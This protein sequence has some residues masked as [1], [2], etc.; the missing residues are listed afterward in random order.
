MALDEKEKK[1]SLLL[2]DLSSLEDYIHDLFNFSPLPICFVSP[3]G[4]IL[5]VNPAF[6]KISNFELNEIISGPIEKLFPKEE[7]E[8]LTQET[9]TKGIVEGKEMIFLPKEKGKMVVQVFTR[10]RKDEKGM[11][12]GYFLGIFDLTNI[13]K[14][15]TEIKETQRALLNMLEDTEEARRRSEEERSK[16]LTII[17]NFADGLL[18]FDAENR[19]SLINPEAEKFFNI[20]G[21]EIINRSI[22]EL[23]TVPSFGPLV[24]LVGKEIKRVFRKEFK[25]KEDLVLEI[26][27]IPIIREGEIIGT[28]IILH[29]ITREKMIER[30]KTEFV[31]ISAHQLRTPLSAIKWTLRMLLDGDLGEIT[32]EQRE[33]IEKTYSSNER[34]IK[35]INDLLN[36]TRIEEGRYLHKP[37]LTDIE[38]MIDTLINSFGEL[39]AR[40]KIKIEFKKPKKKTPMIEVDA[41]KIK[42]AINNLIDNAIRYNQPG[43]KVTVTLT[44]DRNK[45]KISVSDKGI[46][47]AKDQQKRVFTKFF[48]SVNAMRIE[49]EGTG[50]GLFIAKNIIEAHG[51]K[52]WFESAEGKGTTFYL[53]LP[54]KAPELGKFLSASQTMME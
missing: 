1:I 22:S 33:L 2:E 18:V 36:V 51:G 3:L 19:L 21:P 48:R 40:K 54:L 15:E 10:T 8:K 6:E 50:L 20:K 37:I 34:M 39:I 42:L 38:S 27:T 44:Q 14:T 7:V 35:L 17:T 26:S 9:L 49:T 47:I 53:T 4:V 32:D 12:V 29:D 28:S 30:M 23:N 11:V 24:N 45:I 43:G 46:G 41:E 52:I 25:L 5:E 31:S 13:K 16:T